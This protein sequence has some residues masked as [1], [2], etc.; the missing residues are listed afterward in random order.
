MRRKSNFA[1]SDS[2]EREDERCM[3]V[4]SNDMVETVCVSAG[5]CEKCVC[6]HW[7]LLARVLFYTG[8]QEHY[9]C[10]FSLV[11]SAFCKIDS[12]RCEIIL[13]MKVLSG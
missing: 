3:G 12:S 5:M 10:S 8:F 9:T 13:N 7:H 2:E 11:E 4:H 6:V 1:P